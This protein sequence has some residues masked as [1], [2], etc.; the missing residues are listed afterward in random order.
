[1]W[2]RLLK[3]GGVA[4]YVDGLVVALLAFLVLVAGVDWP[5]LVIVLGSVLLHEAGHAAVAAAHKLRVG[6]IYLH[7]VPF[8]YVQRGA[9]KQELRVALGG[10]LTNLLMGVALVAVAGGFPGWDLEAWMGDPWSTAAGVNLLMG[11]LNLVPALPA[12]G[13][14]ALRALL[15]MR[16]PA[17]RAYARTARVGT[18][19]GVLVL[20]LALVLWSWPDSVTVAALG[21]FFIVVAWREALA[22]Q[23][24]RR[25]ERKKE[26]VGD[27]EAPG[28][29]KS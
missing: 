1:M 15:M 22:G 5:I 28:T 27:A 4:L 24:E 18:F 12:D 6:G 10:P 13:G 23:R 25:R 29:V 19:V 14:R 17:A 9:P 16:M 8:A 11:V 2:I 26:T 7:L 21:V 20:L 3:V